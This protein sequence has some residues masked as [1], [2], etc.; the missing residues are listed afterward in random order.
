[1]LTVCTSAAG[2]SPFAPSSPCAGVSTSILSLRRSFICRCLHCRPVRARLAAVEKAWSLQVRE[3]AAAVASQCGA[4][5]QVS[6]IAGEA[7]PQQ[8]SAVAT[9]GQLVVTTP[10]KLAQILREGWLTAAMLEQRLQVCGGRRRRLVGVMSG[11]VG[12][13][14]GGCQRRPQPDSWCLVHHPSWRRLRQM[15]LSAD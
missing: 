1:M 10:A 6:A 11:E 4:D 12:Q 8:R 2:V 14:E 9:A 13:D 5:L 15:C 3:E 7:G